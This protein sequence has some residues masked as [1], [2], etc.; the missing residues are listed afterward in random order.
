LYSVIHGGVLDF[1]LQPNQPRDTQFSEKCEREF[2]AFAEDY[3]K[4]RTGKGLP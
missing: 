4:S 2:N 3:E 1:Y